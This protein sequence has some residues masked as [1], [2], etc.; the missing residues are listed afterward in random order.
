M[1]KRINVGSF[2]SFR[3]F[4]WAQSVRSDANILDMCRL[5]ILYGRNYS[6]KTTLS[7]I[8]RSFE[9][10]KLPKNIHAPQFE[11]RTEEGSLTQNDLETHELDIRVYNR[12]FVDEYLSFLK[13]SAGGDI[14]TFAVIG[15]DNKQI[16][17]RIQEKRSEL[18]S[19]DEKAGLRFQWHRENEE[20][21]SK[22][23]DSQQA[24]K[25][26]TEKLRRHAND[27]IKPNRTFGYPGYNISGIQADIAAVRDKDDA[28]LGEDAAKSREQLLSEVALPDITQSVSFEPSFET[29][30]ETVR[31]L[32]ERQ[33]APSQPIQDLLNNAVLQ[34]WVKE[35]IGHHRD[36]RSD[37]G[38]CGQALP[39]GLWEKLDA[40]FN[41]ESS[42]LDAALASGI[43]AVESEIE[44]LDAVP[45]P[46]KDDFYASKRAEFD[47]VRKAF[48]QTRRLYGTEARKLIKALTGRRKNVFRCGTV[49]EV[50]D[51]SRSL[52]EHIS[53]INALIDAN[54]DKT[55]SLPQDQSRARKELRLSAIAQFVRDIDLS[56]EERKV[57][58]LRDTAQTRKDTADATAAKIK[59]LEEEIE[60]LQANLQDERKGAEKV[61]EYLNHFFGHDGLKLVA[62]E[63]GREA[64][65]R[66]QI[67]RGDQ[68]AYNLSEGECS[69][70]SFCYFI[71]RL[72]DADT[73]G[74]D[75][76]I[77]ID[78][79][80]SSLDANHIFFV[81]SLIESVL[82]KPE[83]NQ[84][85]TNRYRYAQLY[86]STH[87]LDFFKYLKRLSM[88]RANNGGTEFLLIEKEGPASQIVPMPK[89]LKDYQTEFHYLFHQVYRCRDGQLG[90][91]NHE[92]FY[93]FGNNLRKFLEAYLFYKYPYKDDHT[94]PLERL[95][96]FFGDDATATA[97]TNRVSNEL[98]HLEE[99]FDRSMRPIEIPE[100]PAVANFV[101]DK[102]FEKDKDQFNALLKSIGEPPRE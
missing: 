61:N 19:V 17:S 60:Q 102:M 68:P 42:D 83:K 13:D 66:F 16:E 97:L 51:H 28:L 92:I 39:P 27:V 26:L 41:Q 20:Y 59:A 53:T 33:V 86:V 69:L 101:L 91:D 36:K 11:F 88:P 73:H 21:R 43:E 78:D 7:R 12:D 65:Y 15:S 38:F 10:R 3:D 47:S 29:L 71:A 80:I 54:N 34:A 85:G 32:V 82:A 52:Q 8:F 57:K 89:Y 44:N 30:R 63:D 93:N 75:L 40:H 23:R 22:L 70:V 72:E 14:K 96:M 9:C 62:Q 55:E 48:V 18:G 84:D 67:M 87:N 2:G 50:E 79:P 37:C 77:Y 4:D 90:R 25:D 31:E 76:I 64:K 95:R 81:Y 74:K 49:P 45:L 100:I 46:E 58:K 35:G 99:I 56:V 6:G 5:N 94:S 98:S 24:S 1:I